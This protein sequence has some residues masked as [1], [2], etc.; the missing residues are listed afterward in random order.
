VVDGLTSLVDKSLVFVEASG[1][2]LRYRMLETL[3]EYASERLEESGEGAVLTAAHAGWFAGLVSVDNEVA[4]ESWLAAIDAD[5]ANVLAALR[6]SDPSTAATM[7]LGLEEY[8]HRRGHWTEACEQLAAAA[9]RCDHPPTQARLTGIDGWFRYLRGDSTTAR[10]RSQSALEI[11]SQ[12][13]DPEAE[14]L[15][16]NTL[17][18]LDWQDG[19]TDAARTGFEQ[20]LALLR[21]LGDQKRQAGRLSNLGLLAT[22]SQDWASARQF[23]GEAMRI[24]DGVGDRQGIGSCRCNLA[25]LDL[26]S[27]NP[28]SALAH[29]EAGLACFEECHDLPGTVYSLANVAEAQLRLGRLEDADRAA[30]DALSR[31]AESEIPLLA[32][33]LLELRVRARAHLGDIE[34]ARHFLAL[35]DAARAKVA[36]PRDT[37]LVQ[38]LDALLDNAGVPT[39]EMD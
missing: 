26:S 35:A 30:A 1:T 19:D 23:L 25:D 21:T 38:E 4:T 16:L 11:A 29:A 36:S 18:F 22:V 3:R 34:S 32:P 13:A 5:H 12:C 39:R 15:A 2:R 24:Y 10:Q 20:S 7:A 14:S 31:C 27:G 17:A 33:I 28:E 37:S 8:W 6:D 9:T